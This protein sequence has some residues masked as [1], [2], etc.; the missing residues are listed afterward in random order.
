M[1]M[2]ARVFV[3]IIIEIQLAK[4]FASIPKR[5]SMLGSTAE[6]FGSAPVRPET[7]RSDERRKTNQAS[8]TQIAGFVAINCAS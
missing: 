2:H 7:Y 4:V 5:E 1:G 3:L 6:I 8:A